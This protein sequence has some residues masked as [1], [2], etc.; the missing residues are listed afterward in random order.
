VV[1]P[2][3]RL[4]GCQRGSY[5]DH[6][7]R[8]TDACEHLE[9]DSARRPNDFRGMAQTSDRCGLSHYL[10]K[11]APLNSPVARRSDNAFWMDRYVFHDRFHRASHPLKSSFGKA[12]AKVNKFFC[13]RFSG[14]EKWHVILFPLTGILKLLKFSIGLR[15]NTL[16]CGF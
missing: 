15:K 16:F 9:R 4:A 12:G 1:F 11:Q 8:D 6:L 13:F 3:A 10:G 5:R 7:D 2:K 14:G